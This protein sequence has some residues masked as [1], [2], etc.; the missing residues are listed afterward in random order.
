MV[1]APQSH[2]TAIKASIVACVALTT[3]PIHV[4]DPT[5]DCQTKS[6]A[7]VIS[8]KQVNRDIAARKGLIMGGH[9]FNDPK[10]G[11]RSRSLLK[12]V[13]M[14]EFAQG[15]QTTIRAKTSKDGQHS[16]LNH[17]EPHYKRC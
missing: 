3:K 17:P 2:A 7:P 11:T 12:G 5:R 8:P 6:K 10:K 4:T 14:D 16:F 9:V 15:S 13:G 1:V